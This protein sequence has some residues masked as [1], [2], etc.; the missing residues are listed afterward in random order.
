MRLSWSEGSTSH[1][2]CGR[3]AP[4]H[5]RCQ[6]LVP[7]QVSSSAWAWRG[8]ST[9]SRATPFWTSA[10]AA[11][12]STWSSVSASAS[13][14]V[15]LPSGCRVTAAARCCLQMQI[16]GVSFDPCARCRAITARVSMHA[17][18]LFQGKAP[19]HVVASKPVTRGEAK[20]QSALDCRRWAARA[21]PSATGRR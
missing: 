8:C 7:F 11:S 15:L 18:R 14:S 12:P 9:T 16:S 20:H 21:S 3:S 6:L 10:P 4:Q 19:M 13:R 5:T 2:M 1:C 17:R